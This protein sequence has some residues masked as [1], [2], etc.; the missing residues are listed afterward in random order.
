MLTEKQRWKLEVAR[1][2]VTHIAMVLEDT[3]VDVFKLV[4]ATETRHAAFDA[5]KKLQEARG[6]MMIFIDALDG[7]ENKKRE[8]RK[9][10]DSANLKMAHAMAEEPTGRYLARLIKNAEPLVVI[11]GPALGTRE[12]KPGPKM[13]GDDKELLDRT[14]HV[15]SKNEPMNSFYAR[16]G[17]G[18]N[19]IRVMSK[20]EISKFVETVSANE[21]IKP[22]VGTFGRPAPQKFLLEA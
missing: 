14:A 3:F 6:E 9:M 19:Q 1:N 17:L 12:G 15:R 4:E 18:P 2:T 10:Q 20:S 7:V 11:A 5:I 13:V 21:D 16:I 8:E 22:P